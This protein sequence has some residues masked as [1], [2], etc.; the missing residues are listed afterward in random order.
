MEQCREVPQCGPPAQ[1][2]VAKLPQCPVH[3]S[4]VRAPHQ[5]SDVACWTHPNLV[6]IAGGER[7]ALERDRRQ[8]TRVECG[9]QRVLLSQQAAV[10]HERLAIAVGHGLGGLCWHGLK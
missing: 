9:D 10:V 2:P 3:P 7:E 6:V 5:Q 8:S 4:H 1:R